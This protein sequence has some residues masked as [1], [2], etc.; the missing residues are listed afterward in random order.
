MELGSHNESGKVVSLLDADKP[1]GYI[2]HSLG[3]IDVYDN[4]TKQYFIFWGDTTGG[5]Y[6]NWSSDGYVWHNGQLVVHA[7]DPISVVGGQFYVNIGTVGDNSFIYYMRCNE[8]VNVPIRYNRGQIS[9]NGDISWGSESVMVSGG[10]TYGNYPNGI[11]QTPSGYI[12]ACYDKVYYNQTIKKVY[13]T[14]SQNAGTWTNYTGY[15]KSAFENF[16]SNQVVREAYIYGINDTSAY[17]ITT[18]A[19]GSST[20]FINGKFIVN[21][22]LGSMQNVTGYRVTDLTTAQG[23]GFSGT[24]NPE[25][26]ALYVVYHSQTSDK[27]IRI[28][29]INAT[30]GAITDQDR[31][32][33]SQAIDSVTY[34]ILNYDINS[35]TLNVNWVNNDGSIWLAQKKLTGTNWNARIRIGHLPAEQSSFFYDPNTI[36]ERTMGHIVLDLY[37][38]NATG[39]HHVFAFTYASDITAPDY[40]SL[41]INTIWNYA[42]YI[43]GI[44]LFAL[45][46]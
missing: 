7:P 11:A 2:R 44:S 25:S 20:S 12:W 1:C 30:T 34:P 24:Y 15:P 33:S 14:F 37:C 43:L 42:L 26:K 8:Q 17:V 10:D 16:N 31:I 5:V 36:V 22:V 6:Y 27:K 32:V 45:M 28:T 29:T 19:Q 35:S 13:V 39:Q 4:K 41:T 9:A 18:P 46:D 21:H 38:D 40:T 3:R 23:R